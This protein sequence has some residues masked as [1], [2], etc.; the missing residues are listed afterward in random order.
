[1]V[2]ITIIGVLIALLLPAVQAA[3]EAAR[4]MSCSNNLRQF[5]LALHNYH[6]SFECFPGLGTD[7][8]GLAGASS[9]SN[10]MFSV[11]SRLLPYM[12]QSQLQ[13]SID[14]TKP[15]LLSDGTHGTGN[16]FGYHV[17]DVVSK[18]LSVTT[19]PSET[20]R[21]PL[22]M[23]KYIYTDEAHTAANVVEVPTAPGNYVL[24]SGSDIFRISAT[25]EFDGMKKLQTNGMFYYNSSVGI[26]AI[27][28]GT[29]NTMAMSEAI[30]S[31]GKNYSAPLGDVQ[32]NKSYRHLVGTNLTLTNSSGLVVINPTELETN[33]GT[34]ARSWSG[35]RCTSWVWGA[36]YN[37]VYG[38]FLPPNSKIPSTN[39]M[40]HGFYGAYSYHPGGVN[41]LLADGSVRLVS[42]TIDYE[43]WKSAATISNGE[44]NSG[45]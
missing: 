34:S 30:V 42:D 33:Y 9:L 4:R 36:P 37:S 26:N 8:H 15:L 2:V 11:Q 18:L 25:T 29:S 10:S 41:V 20:T 31:D 21:Q 5:G 32:A 14:Y 6:S 39:W 22:S 24:N 7:G 13:S 16:T 19:C 17:R 40:N 35:Y 44:V 45:L 3:R 28:D 1:M 12:E 23:G 27:T 38:A 43:T